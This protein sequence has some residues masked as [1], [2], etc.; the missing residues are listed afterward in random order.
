MAEGTPAKE[1]RQPLKASKGKETYYPL[2]A[3]EKKEAL[4]IL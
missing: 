2:E 1:C 3:P 4:P